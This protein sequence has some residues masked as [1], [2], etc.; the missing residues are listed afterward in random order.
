MVAGPDLL[1]PNVTG[2]L[3]VTGGLAVWEDATFNGAARFGAGLSAW[4]HAPP[5]V[6]PS[7]TGARGG[8]AALAS[9][10]AVLVAA[11]FALDT[12]TA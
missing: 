11:G 12:T 7:F 5:T 8:N 10:I 1:T 6:Q 9:V 4:G 3:T 2:D